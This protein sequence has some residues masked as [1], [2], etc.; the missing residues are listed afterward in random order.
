M[1]VAVDKAAS[2]IGP[3]ARATPTDGSL[4][5]NVL[6]RPTST[7]STPEAMPSVT[8]LDGI[9]RVPWQGKWVW[10]KNEDTVAPL[11][12]AFSVGTGTLVYGQ[13][14]ALAA[15]DQRIGWRISPGETVKFIVPKDAT[16][17]VTIQPGAAAASTFAM[18]VAEGPVVIR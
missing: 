15:G 16:H 11:E 5:N 6:R 4:G 1:S 18:F 12:F 7:T 14:A 3:L 8:L 9:T 13:T 10:V 2:T 17:V